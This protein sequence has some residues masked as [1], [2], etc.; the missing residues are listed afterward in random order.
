[1]NLWESLLVAFDNVRVNKMR[2]FLTIIGI[3]VGVAAV[4]AVVSI[5]QAGKSSVVS[6]LSQFDQNAFLAL[7]N[8][9]A[10]QGQEEKAAI[11]LDDME[12]I[13]RMEGVDAVAGTLQIPV[14]AQLGRTTSKFTV[15]G[16]T[17]EATEVQNIKLSAGRF[18]SKGEERARQKVV[19]VESA[20][21]E[22]E[23]GSV[24][25]A[26]NRKL[27]LGG[28]VFRIIGVTETQESML[29]F[30]EK[31]WQAVMPITAVPAGD[32]TLNKVSTIFVKADAR[33]ADDLTPLMADVRKLLAK[34]HNLPNNAYQTQSTADLQ[35]SVSSVFNILQT[36]VGSIAGI[37]LFVG[38]IGVMNIMLVSVTERT[39]E[40]GIRKAI[41]A[42]PGAI[43][44]QFL[45][46]AVILSF[47]GGLLG[48]LVGLGAAGIFS[49][50]TDWP[51][52]I[53]WWTILLAFGFSAAVGIFFGLYPANKAARMQP[54]ESLRYE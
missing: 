30:G 33:A 6:D 39:R 27:K 13:R 19:L 34:R 41:G 2:S 11:T 26:L 5:G 15:T 38:G 14:E 32:E 50:I 16:T 45:V 29:Q 24:E 31:M 1:M 10:V 9:Q 7:P 3:V 17:S 4:I 52:L 43:M 49:L 35:A 20:F 53:S 25:G 23:Y 21:A 37:S 28:K 44:T 22:Q 12:A 36:I 51:F 47:I 8:F 46:E 42:T 40:I 48:T 18:F 54:I